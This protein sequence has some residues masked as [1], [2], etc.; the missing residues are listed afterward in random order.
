MA[1]YVRSVERGILS[2]SLGDA[3]L[4]QGPKGDTGNGI[5]SAVLNGD[6]TLTLNFTD[7]SSYTTPSIRGAQGI[8]G[9]KGSKGEKGEPGTNGTAGMDGKDGAAATGNCGDS[10]DWCAGDRSFYNKQRNRKCGRAQFYHP[11]RRDGTSRPWFGRHGN[12]DL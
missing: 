2:V 8:Q 12:G 3:K 11:A 7:G 5:A 10:G 4:V 1:V 9:E 6:Y